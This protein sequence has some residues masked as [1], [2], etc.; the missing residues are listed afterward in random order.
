[1]DITQVSTEEVVNDPESISSS[2]QKNTSSNWC[3]LGRRV[4]RLEIVF[5]CQIIL[6][7]AVVAVALVNLTR[8]HGPDQL[9][10]AL[11]GSC[12]G[13]V[14]PAPTIAQSSQ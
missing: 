11:L 6:V 3:L 7:Y 1:M 12:L 8:G 5:F 13:Y 9:W 4:P 14:L 10:I 2:N